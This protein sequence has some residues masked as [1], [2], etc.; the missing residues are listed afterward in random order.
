MKNIVNIQTVPW[1]RLTL[2]RMDCVYA[3]YALLLF[4]MG[5]SVDQY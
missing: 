3:T 4:I 2:V 5:I 1:F